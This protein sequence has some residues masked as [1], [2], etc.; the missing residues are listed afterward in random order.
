M[1]QL[2]FFATQPDLEQVFGFVYAETDFRVFESY[3]D[4]GQDLREFS[5]F[6]ALATAYQVGLDVHG[7]GTAVLLQMWSP[8]VMTKP[9]VV[10][11]A[12]D[13]QKCRGHTFR[14]RISGYGLCQLYLGGMHGRII[15][16]THYGHFSERGASRW[17]DTSHVNW[18]ALKK[19][20]GRFQ[21]HVSRRLAVAKAPG[22][23]VLPDAFEKY[24]E[25]YELRYAAGHPAVYKAVP[26]K[27]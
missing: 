4:L 10:R 2:N 26:L 23:P 18:E 5:S 6:D 14:Y 17:G 20:S 21:R 3:S 16:H 12:L 1:P 7:N 8:S 19:I 25:G 13:P 15:T 22:N 11:L 9:E 24:K 27:S